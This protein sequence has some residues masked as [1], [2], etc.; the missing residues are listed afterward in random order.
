MSKNICSRCTEPGLWGDEAEDQLVEIEQ[1][2]QTV[3]N[4]PVSDLFSVC[5]EDDL[6]F[7]ME[8]SFYKDETKEKLPFYGLEH[9]PL[10]K[11]KIHGHTVVGEIDREMVGWIITDTPF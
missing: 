4:K 7:D 6:D 1:A 2:C 5:T 9:T 8:A 10:Y 3:F 11:F